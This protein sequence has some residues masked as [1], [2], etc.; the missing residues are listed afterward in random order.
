MKI[1]PIVGILVL[2]LVRI[3]PGTDELQRIPKLLGSDKMG[4]IRAALFDGISRVGEGMRDATIQSPAKNRALTG[5][6]LE[7]PKSQYNRNID[8]RP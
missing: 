8:E 1:V 2:G 4:K 3:V 5:F 7:S 6:S